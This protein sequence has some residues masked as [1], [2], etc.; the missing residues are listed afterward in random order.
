MLYSCIKERILEG[1][2]VFMK[3]VGA[4]N[5]CMTL[6]RQL[7]WSGNRVPNWTRSRKLSEVT[8]SF[9]ALMKYDSSF[10][11]TVGNASLKTSSSARP[12]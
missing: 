3:N 9:L 12:S 1:H 8:I 2:D 10:T 4:Y 5:P 7:A 6:R 11:E